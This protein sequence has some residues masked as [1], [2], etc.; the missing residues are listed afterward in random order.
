MSTA[1]TVLALLQGC[2]TLRRLKAIHAR[3]FVHGLQSDPSISAKLLH[4]CAVSVSGCLAYARTL[5]DRIE[6]PQTHDWSSII[7]GFAVGASPREALLYYNGMLGSSFS[8]ADSHSF[9]FALKACERVGDE[10]KCREIHG[11]VIRSGYEMDVVVCTN[12]MRCYVGNGLVEVA[13]KVFEG[14]SVRDLVSWNSMISCYSRAGLHHEALGLYRRMRKEN[15]GVDGFT[16]VGLLSCCVHVGA[17]N[18]GVELHRRASREGFLGNIYVANALIDLYGK[19][20][21]LAEALFVFNGMPKRDVFT[22]NSMITAYGVNGCADEAVLLFRQMLREGVQPSSITFLGLLLGCSHRGLLDKGVEFFH[23][24]S[25]KFNLRPEIKHYGCMVDLYGRAGKLEKALEI[26]GTSPF[27]VDPVIWRTLLGS[28]KIH[29]NVRIGEI[30]IKNLV[31][32]G[33]CNAGDCILLATIYAECNDKQGVARMRRLIKSQGIRT[34]P[35]W[36]WIEIGNQVHRFFVD[37]Q[38]H[39]D[40]DEI[41]RKLE[42]VIYR[43]SLAGYVDSKFQLIM[44][45]LT[46]EGHLESSSKYHSEKLAITFG[47]AGTPDGTN[48]RIVKNLR[49]CRDCHS[50]AKFV[51]QAFSREIIVRD[52]VRFHHFKG[53]VCSCKEYW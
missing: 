47:L 9:S 6:C 45:D 18:M 3:V 46:C 20:G 28:C 38:S 53:G 34:T 29:Q 37:D 2:N 17:L 7:R 43:A 4:F 42:E 15:V 41:Y 24:M 32:L 22:W 19:C 14:M 44:P 11:T 30:A 5:F 10:Q 31:Q 35:G 52:R 1:Q 23:M 12:L 50:F 26:I 33:A 49:I 39:P 16:L 48:I 36:S 40:R 8:F 21:D 13:Q 27:L 51:S 25:S